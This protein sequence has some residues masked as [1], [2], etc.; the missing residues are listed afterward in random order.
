MNAYSAK[1]RREPKTCPIIMY[2][3]YAQLPADYRLLHEDVRSRM[4][5]WCRHGSGRIR[6]D[7][8]PWQE[9][10][11]GAYVW[12]P[13]PHR[14][15]YHAGEQEWHLGGIHLIP[16]YPCDVAPSW[17]VPHFD[18]TAAQAIPDGAL[19]QDAFLADLET[20]R[21]GSFHDESE[22]VHLA[23]YI[24]GWFA[25]EPRDSEM[26]RH[27]AETLCRALRLV[28][29]R[30]EHDADVWPV[31]LHMMI[32]YA[33]EHLPEVL[34]IPA[35][36]RAGQCSAATVSRQFLRYTSFSPMLWVQRERMA[37][38][39]EYLRTTPL[40][41]GEVGVRVGV[42]DPYYFSRLFRQWQGMSPTAFRKHMT[43]L[44]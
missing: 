16:S 28:W 13:W 17:L 33:R 41:V 18:D 32:T 23:E 31:S 5:L 29:G 8:R 1:R 40:R 35:L 4:L 14:I 2:A 24:V 19:Q 27:L 15:A 10:H 21:S 39:A 3:N 37:R 44:L 36:Q 11:A 12:L 25:H 38:A 9:L 20:F 30:R 26:A 42:S 43:L 6:V 22:L 34:D 7:D